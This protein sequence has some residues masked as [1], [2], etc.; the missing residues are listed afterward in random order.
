MIHDP[1]AD[2]HHVENEYSIGLTAW[3]DL[4]DL[5]AIILAVAHDQYKNLPHAE[6]SDK[7]VDPK[8]LMD[9]KSALQ[10]KIFTDQ[11]IRVWRL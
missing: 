5:D 11:G 6:L 7:L 2:D 3:S 8:L 4:K 10:H 1:I 9:V